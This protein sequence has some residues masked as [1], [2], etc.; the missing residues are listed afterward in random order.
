MEWCTHQE[1]NLPGHTNWEQ[2]PWRLV[3]A[4]E[5]R[6]LFLQ[7]LRVI[8][9]S[10]GLFIVMSLTGLSFDLNNLLNY[11]L[12]PGQKSVSYVIYAWFITKRGVFQQAGRARL[13]LGLFPLSAVKL[14]QG[15]W[16]TAFTSTLRS[17]GQGKGVY[18]CF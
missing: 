1:I 9:C 3:R 14:Q 16:P 12:K 18:I 15:L 5:D 8:R 17:R 11:P 4:L 2:Q 13:F 7:L 6:V 10:P